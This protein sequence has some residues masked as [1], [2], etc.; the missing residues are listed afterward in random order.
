MVELN[1]PIL[2]TPDMRPPRNTTS[3]TCGDNITDIC[4]E[5]DD[6]GLVLRCEDDGKIVTTDLDPGPPEDDSVSIKPAY[7]LVNCDKG[8]HVSL[9]GDDSMRTST[10]AG[11]FVALSSG[12]G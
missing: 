7:Q 6:G 4:P 5:E 2:E 8:S 11:Q 10:R 1:P 9:V 12:V 3:I